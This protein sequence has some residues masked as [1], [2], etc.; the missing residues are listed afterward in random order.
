[1]KKCNHLANINEVQHY[2]I[3]DR[4]IFSLASS[5]LVV[6]ANYSNIQ[7]SFVTYYSNIQEFCVCVCVCVWGGGGGGGGST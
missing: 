4:C 5:G 3:G 6:F 1:M 7:E 2:G